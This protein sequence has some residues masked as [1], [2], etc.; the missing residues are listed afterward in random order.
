MF[1]VCTIYIWQVKKFLE[2][3]FGSL[4]LGFSVA[5]IKNLVLTSSHIRI[6]EQD[7]VNGTF[8]YLVY[9]YSFLNTF[10]WIFLLWITQKVVDLSDRL[11][12]SK[13]LLKAL[14]H[15]KYYWGFLRYYHHQES[16]FF[17][18][19]AS[20]LLTFSENLLEL[21]SA[22]KLQKS[23]K[24]PRGFIIMWHL[25]NCTQLTVNHIRNLLFAYM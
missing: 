9:L 20:N 10:W 4:A 12:F 17:G 21:P 6:T 25:E 11:R 24:F 2:D 7:I 1:F 15:Q 13:T 5:I 3:Y 19:K 16:F 18:H 23:F 22:F 14:L 8:Q